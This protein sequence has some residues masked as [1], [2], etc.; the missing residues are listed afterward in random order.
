[1]FQQAAKYNT[2]MTNIMVRLFDLEIK[3]KHII[4]EKDKFVKNLHE[5][6][7][8]EQKF[9]TYETDEVE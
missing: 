4:K 8:K 9:R 6:L 3:N 1:M 2:Q 7:E 5:V